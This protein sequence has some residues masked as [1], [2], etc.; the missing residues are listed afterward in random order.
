[1]ALD[2]ALEET[3][4]ALCES[5]SEAWSPCPCVGV[6]VPRDE[7]EPAYARV[8][9]SLAALVLPSV[10]SATPGV[11]PAECAAGER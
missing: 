4:S 9:K 1:L 11:W 7:P 3:E 6:G 2:S 8:L 10:C 5:D